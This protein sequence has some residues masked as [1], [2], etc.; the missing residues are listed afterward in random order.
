MQGKS[1]GNKF[2]QFLFFWKSPYLPSFLKDNFSGYKILDL[3]IF[4]FLLIQICHCTLFVC[5]HGFWWEVCCNFYLCLSIGKVFFLW[6]H[7]RL[8]FSFCNLYMKYF[9][10]NCWN[11]S[12]LVFYELLRSVVWCLTLIWEKC[13]V[14]VASHVSCTPFFF[15]SFWYS[16]DTYVTWFV[17]SP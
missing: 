13:L 4:L 15:L 11:L 8:I 17:V 14:I 7:S 2:P 10:V 3:C 1:T 12:C 5:L 9:S 6:L 16:C